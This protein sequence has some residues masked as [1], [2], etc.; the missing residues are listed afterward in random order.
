LL[1]SVGTAGG[2]WV[3]VEAEEGDGEEIGVE[4][5]GVVVAGEQ[6]DKINNPINKIKA[7]TKYIF[8]FIQLQND[9]KWR[10]LDLKYLLHCT[11]ARLFISNLPV[12]NNDNSYFKRNQNRCLFL[13]FYSRSSRN[14][15][16]CQWPDLHLLSGAELE[17]ANAGLFTKQLEPELPRRGKLSPLT[18]IVDSEFPLSLRASLS[19]LTRPFRKQTFAEQSRPFNKQT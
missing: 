15:S 3:G 16:T 11:I 10:Y 5:G 14:P 4:E 19:N 13:L 12:K 1:G 6:E 18:P 2:V 17:S 8:L 7:A 9:R